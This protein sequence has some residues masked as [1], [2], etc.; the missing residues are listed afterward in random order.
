MAHGESRDITQLLQ[1][2]S[3]GDKTALN[4]LVPLVYRELRRLAATYL[5]RERRDHTLQPT[6]LV[7]ETYLRL[8]EQIRVECRTRSQF[9]GIAANLMRQIL[10]NHARYH[11]AVKRDGG[12]RVALEE[13]AVVVD[14]REPDLVALDGAL[15]RLALLDQ[16]QSRIVELRFF[17]GL[18][19]DEIAEIVGVSPITVKR[20]WRMARAVLHDELHVPVMD[21]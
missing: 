12:S 15:E 1:S 4:E 20:E 16:R 14:Q 21:A 11:R 2:W 8:V 10:V 13:S 17:G 3:C 9:L 18:T 6:A 19:E 5:H 7:H